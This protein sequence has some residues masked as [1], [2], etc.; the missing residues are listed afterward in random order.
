MGDDDDDENNS[1]NDDCGDY[2][3]EWDYDFQGCVT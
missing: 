3:E 2:L 1:D